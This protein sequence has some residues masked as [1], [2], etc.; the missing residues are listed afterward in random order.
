MALR[1]LKNVTTL[2]YFSDKC[3]ACGRCVEVC[4]HAVFTISGK[5]EKAVLSSRDLCIECGAC[6]RNCPFD[7]IRVRAGVGCAAGILLSSL[8]G[9]RTVC[10]G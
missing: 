5:G 4:P 9:S 10:C 8:K 3:C 6:R 7:A 1:H 2:E